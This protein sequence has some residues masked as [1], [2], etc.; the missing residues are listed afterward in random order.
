MDGLPDR[1]V[2]SNI[3]DKL[4]RA[5]GDLGADA[6]VA[7]IAAMMA[8]AL[9]LCPEADEAAAS[10]AAAHEAAADKAAADEAAPDTVAADEPAADKAAAVD[11]ADSGQ[12]GSAQGAR[13]ADPESDDE[14]EVEAEDDLPKRPPDG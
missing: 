3:C 6:D 14:P 1:A 7:R 2:V 13:A 4:K 10:D 12:A 8:A 9:A 11:A 5:A